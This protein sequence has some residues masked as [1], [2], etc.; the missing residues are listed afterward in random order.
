MVDSELMKTVAPGGGI[1]VST[2]QIR[3]RDW[4]AASSVCSA[5]SSPSEERNSILL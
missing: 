4:I 3:K 2:A 5:T 1:T